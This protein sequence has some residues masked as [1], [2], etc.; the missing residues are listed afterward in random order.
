[1]ARIIEHIPDPMTEE[2]CSHCKEPIT[3]TTKY[4]CDGEPYPACGYCGDVIEN[5]WWGW[6]PEEKSSQKIGDVRIR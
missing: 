3:L 1:M 5:P 6:K 2:I 4:D